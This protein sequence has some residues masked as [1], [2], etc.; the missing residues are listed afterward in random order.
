L[1]ARSGKPERHIC[2]TAAQENEW[3]VTSLI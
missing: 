1:I 3:A 2:V